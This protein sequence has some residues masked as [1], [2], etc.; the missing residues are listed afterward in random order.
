[1]NADPDCHHQIN[2]LA[3]PGGYRAAR[4][5]PGRLFNVGQAS[6]LPSE[7]VS[8]SSA[9]FAG[10]AGE[11]PALRWEYVLVAPA[12]ARQRAG[13]SAASGGNSHPRQDAPAAAG[14]KLNVAA[15]ARM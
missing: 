1:M 6:R 3:C 9:G 7:R 8:A 2:R 11:T 14:M 15:G 4:G 12:A 13:C 5:L 10:R